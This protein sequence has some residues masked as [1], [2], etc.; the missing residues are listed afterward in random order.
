M[1]KP[2][3]MCNSG[4]VVVSRLALRRVIEKEGSI[5]PDNLCPPFRRSVAY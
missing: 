1:A 3:G 2:N 4:R 5:G